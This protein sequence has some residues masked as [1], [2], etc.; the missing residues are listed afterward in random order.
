MTQLATS[1]FNSTSTTTTFSDGGTYQQYAGSTL[2]TYLNET[3]YNTLSENIKNAI[4]DQIITQK[5]YSYDNNANSANSTYKYYYNDFSD[6]PADSA[7]RGVTYKDIIT[8]GSR[9]VYALEIDDIFDY[10]GKTEITS[11]EL[12]TMFYNTGT[13]VVDDSW[14][15][16]ANSGDSIEAFSVEGYYGCLNR[17]NCRRAYQARP[18]FLIDLS[19][20]DYADAGN[21]TAAE[22]GWS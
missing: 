17:Y 15:C 2:D 21:P 10:Y 5:V 11:S 16:S 1:K 3:Y 12:N 7:R 13:S 9:H 4:V 22:L 19:K 18:A 6:S 20:V 14:L 8:V